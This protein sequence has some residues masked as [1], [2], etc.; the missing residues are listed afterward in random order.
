[1]RRTAIMAAVLL[2]LAACSTAGTTT[3]EPVTTDGI[4]EDE[5]DEWVDALADAPPCDSLTYEVGDTVAEGLACTDEAGTILNVFALGYD[6]ADGSELWLYEQFTT[7][8]DT[9][10]EFID[11][12]GSYT[13]DALDQA[14][15]GGL[16]D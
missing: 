9:I 12:A 1:M 2:G 16:A 3:D 13:L 15:P 6:C 8:D 4:T 5:L 7:V 14:C 10:V 11:T